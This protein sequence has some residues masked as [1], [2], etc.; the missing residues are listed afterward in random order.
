VSAPVR[1]LVVDPDAAMGFRFDE[2]AYPTAADDQVVVGVHHISLNHGDLN[3]ARSGRVPAGAVLGSD[4]TGVVVQAAS[5][6]TG[7][8]Q[9]ARVVG[10]AAGAF[11]THA[12]VDADAVVA[13]P[14]AVDLAAAVALP[15]AGVA[16]VQALRDGGLSAGKRVLVTG[17][18]GGVGP[19]AVQLAARAGAFVIAAAGSL[20]RAAPLLDLG[21]DGIVA[22]LADVHEP[23]DLVIETVGGTTLV[24][25][26]SLLAAGGSL[27]SVGWA[28]GQ[29]ATFPPYSTVGPARTLS[30]FLIRGPI[31][32]DLSSL[33]Q[34]LAAGM[35]SVTIGWRG[36]WERF[37]EA[38][39]AMLERR[40]NGKAVLDVLAPASD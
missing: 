16:A 4:V 25:A 11:A 24:E 37:E 35:L 8:R 28:S 38:A 22:D 13:V 2:V 10:I 39:L 15:V 30:S 1:A 18:S 21:A 29:P 33:V 31:A 26:W 20:E 34:L 14:D 3:D 9:G 6:G 7:P 5:D 17:A 12:A 27:Q 23:V 19:F 32:P 36:N 40:I